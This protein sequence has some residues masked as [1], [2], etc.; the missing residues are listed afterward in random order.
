MFETHTIL[1]KETSSQLNRAFWMKFLYAKEKDITEQD[2]EIASDLADNWDT[3]A[4]G[5]LDDNIPR[6]DDS[7]PEDLN[8]IRLGIY[9]VSYVQERDLEAARQ[10]FLDIQQRGAEI[11]HSTLFSAG[12]NNV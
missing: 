5:S 6:I 2:W 3:C 1:Y 9:F 11:L 4:C 7:T 8:L 12:E 10:T